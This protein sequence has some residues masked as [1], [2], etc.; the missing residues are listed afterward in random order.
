MKRRNDL[1]LGEAI[2]LMLREYQLDGRLKDFQVRAIWQR[3]MEKRLGNYISEVRVREGVL[4]VTVLSSPLR[5]ELTIA[6]EKIR[7]QL[8]AEMGEPYVREVVIR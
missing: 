8:N 5:Q 1:S 2:R 3:L 7:E 6:R 4:Y